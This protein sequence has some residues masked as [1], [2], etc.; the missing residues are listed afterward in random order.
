MNGG[1]REKIMCKG[2]WDDANGHVKVE[3]DV[4]RVRACETSDHKSAYGSTNRQGNHR[5]LVLQTC[6]KSCVSRSVI[7]ISSD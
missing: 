7:T 5:V 1:S 4:A 2:A 3:Y 6:R